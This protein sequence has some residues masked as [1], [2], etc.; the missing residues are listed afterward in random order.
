METTF[1]I[2]SPLSGSILFNSL[3]TTLGIGLSNGSVVQHF[4]ISLKG[5]SQIKAMYK[6]RL[7]I[8]TTR[9]K[10]LLQVVIIFVRTSTAKF[11][12]IDAIEVPKNLQS[13]STQQA[14]P[15]QWVCNKEDAMEKH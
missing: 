6:Y 14:R 4:S 5:N 11:F 9:Q 12:I 10:Q 8:D 13:M 7:K 3:K 15:M 1:S 2:D